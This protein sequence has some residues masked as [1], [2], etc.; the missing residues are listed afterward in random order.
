MILELSYESI[1][2]LPS[3]ISSLI[4][5]ILSVYDGHIFESR[6][7]VVLNYKDC[8]SDLDYIVYL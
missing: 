7:I 6:D 4:L 1:S 8:A 2:C 5:K 3:L